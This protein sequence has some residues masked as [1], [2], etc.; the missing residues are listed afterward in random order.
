MLHF[1]SMNNNDNKSV[2]SLSCLFHPATKN[3]M[4]SEENEI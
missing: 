1:V 4:F 3:Y 2:Q